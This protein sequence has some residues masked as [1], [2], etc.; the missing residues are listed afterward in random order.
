MI[1]EMLNCLSVLLT[2]ETESCVTAL[3]VELLAE[4]VIP[5]MEIG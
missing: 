4:P 5:E 2:G 1:A 3:L